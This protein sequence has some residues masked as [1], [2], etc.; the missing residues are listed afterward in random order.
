MN[1]LKCCGKYTMKE[2]CS[3]GKKPIPVKPMKYSPEDHYGEY[4]RKAK[5]EQRKK[6]GLI[7]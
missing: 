5:E 3:C 2:K 1:I 6:A 4:R 7:L